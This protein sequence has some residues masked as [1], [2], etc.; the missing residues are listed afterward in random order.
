MGN[1]K[2]FE[3]RKSLGDGNLL[4]PNFQRK[5]VWDKENMRS[6]LASLI[7]NYPTG[8]LLIGTDA[9]SSDLASNK[10]VSIEEDKLKQIYAKKAGISDDEGQKLSAI[11][12]LEKGTDFPCEFLLDGQQRISSLDIIFSDAYY[13]CYEDLKYNNCVRWFLNISKLGFEDLKWPKLNDIPHHDVCEMVVFKDYRISKNGPYYPNESESTL[14]NYCLDEAVN[15]AGLLI[16]LDIIFDLKTY[17]V[18][19]DVISDYLQDGDLIIKEKTIEGKASKEKYDAGD[20]DSDEHNKV[21]SNLKKRRNRWV[22]KLLELLNNIKNFEFQVTEVPAKDFSRLAG[23]F[24]VINISGVSLSTFDLLVAKTVE[25][26]KNLRDV[27]LQSVKG[28]NEELKQRNTYKL[29]PNNAKISGNNEIDQFWTL[30]RFLGER[31]YEQEIDAGEEFPEKISSA[32]CQIIAL[33]AGISRALGDDWAIRPS[34]LSFHKENR[35]EPDLIT[36]TEPKECARSILRLEEK[37]WGFSDNIILERLSKSEINN[38]RSQAAKQLLRSY[39]IINTR[40]GFPYQSFFPYRLMDLAIAC[41]LTDKIWEKITEDPNHIY[42]R[43]IEWWFWSSMFGGAYKESQDRRVKL[44]IPRLILFINEPDLKWSDLADLDNGTKQLSPS[45]GKEVS[46]E[47]FTEG[48]G[49]RDS[50]LFKVDGYSDM[51][52][53]TGDATAPKAM[54]NTIRA[55]VIKNGVKDFK[56]FNSSSKNWIRFEL[57]T[58]YE[59]LAADHLFPLKAWNSF[60]GKDIKRNEPHPINSPMNFTWISQKS[61]SYWMQEPIYKKLEL[62]EAVNDDTDTLDFLNEH[63]VVVDGLKNTY[64]QEVERNDIDNAESV[65]KIFLKQ[66]FERLRQRVN[67]IKPY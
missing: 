9:K 62:K 21:I 66:R 30:A 22:A 55:F 1:R 51:K 16:P 4:I 25:S 48:I 20:I 37:D 52:T 36:T 32:L 13:K 15:D 44:D 49:N 40:L 7:L 27:F 60:A 18:N 42:M 43:K 50:Q 57:N 65:L 26:R 67:D 5:F 47:R 3:I 10:P 38:I 33:C 59:S 28:F 2:L 11:E 6:L 19:S 35:K 31:K 64:K 8:A 46:A 61:N 58:G 34:V 23:I 39:F 45:S 24:S 54:G 53:L 41:V 12:C 14:R 29:I 63:L 17:D 56:H